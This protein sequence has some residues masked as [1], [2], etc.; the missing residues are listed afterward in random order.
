MGKAE[1]SADS[2]AEGANHQ[3]AA[4]G[5]NQNNLGDLRIKR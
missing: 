4:V 2:R 1:N 5:F 3:F